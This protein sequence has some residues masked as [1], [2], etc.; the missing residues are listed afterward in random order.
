MKNGNSFSKPYGLGKDESQDRWKTKKSDSNVKNSNTLSLNI[1]AY[2]NPDKSALDSLFDKNEVSTKNSLKNRVGFGKKLKDVE[3]FFYGAS[4]SIQI[5]PGDLPRI[6]QNSF[7]FPRQSN[8]EE[9]ES[10]ITRFR[11]SQRL[12]NPNDDK[13]QAVID[14]A[15]TLGMDDETLALLY[16]ALAKKEE[17]AG[18]RNK[19]GD[20]NMLADL[21]TTTNLLLSLLNFNKKAFQ[22]YAEK[23][24]KN[25]MR[26]EAKEIV[27]GCLEIKKYMDQH[28][29]SNNSWSFIE[30]RYLLVFYLCPPLSAMWKD[31]SPYGRKIVFQS[32]FRWATNSS[33]VAEIGEEETVKRITTFS[34]EDKVFSI[35]LA[36]IPVTFEI[37]QS[38]WLWHKGKISGARAAQNIANVDLTSA[39]GF[40]GAVGGAAIGHL[41]FGGYATFVEGLFAGFVGN[42]LSRWLTNNIFN[43]PKTRALENAYRYLDV[44]HQA[45]DSEVEKAYKKRRLIDHP[46]KGGSHEA[47]CKLQ[48]CYTIIKIDRCKN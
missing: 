24:I 7:E 33:G 38:V 42:Q 35:I 19:S 4:A 29:G 43:L 12:L 32:A 41:L 23:L 22:N 2:E 15:C 1:V 8:G 37:V 44:H 40:G 48:V 21:V 11:A 31:I 25:Y 45:S 47:F 46:D 36:F 34:N 14:Y 39:T 3:Q 28:S 27:K 26:E 6:S 10:E 9:V 17:E 13:Y 16:M 5:L 20:W 18:G 30:Q